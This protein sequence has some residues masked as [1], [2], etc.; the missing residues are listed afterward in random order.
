MAKRC[1]ES[2]SHTA[3][4]ISCSTTKCDLSGNDT[5][6]HTTDI[7]NGRFS[8]YQVEIYSGTLNGALN[9][10]GKSKSVT[11]YPIVGR[12]SRA[13]TTVKRLDPVRAPTTEEILTRV[14]YYDSTQRVGNHTFV[15][16]KE[17]WPIDYEMSTL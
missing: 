15:F 14:E 13:P 5:A 12:N 11:R 2:V 9:I 1:S 4:D 3:V 17:L 7:F 8:I 16:P 10:A 6:Q